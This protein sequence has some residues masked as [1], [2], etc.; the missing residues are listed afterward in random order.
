MPDPPAETL[1]TPAP[2]ASAWPTLPRPPRRA[3]DAT[4]ACVQFARAAAT[5]DTTTGN[6]G[7]SRQGAAPSHGTP[8]LQAVLDGAAEGRIREQETWQQHRA[9]VTA[10]AAPVVDDAHDGPAQP[11]TGQP[12]PG[13]PV[14]VT[15]TGAARGAGGWTAV[16]TPYRLD[17]LTA[18]EPLTG[19]SMTSR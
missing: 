4:S 10:T 17:C 13:T 14:P 3:L 15:F 8:Q 19:S 2:P 12:Q 11:G 16:I 18:Q 9:R 5:V 7:Q 1:D 6:I